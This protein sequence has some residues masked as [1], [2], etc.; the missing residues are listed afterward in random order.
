M[1]QARRHHREN[2]FACGR[3]QLE[4]DQGFTLVEMIV[5]IAILS[6]FFILIGT[7]FALLMRSEKTVMQSLLLERTI[8]RLSEQFRKDV[9]F[10]S[11]PNDPEPTTEELSEIVLAGVGNESVR[12]RVSKN[13]IERQLINQ[14]SVTARDSFVMPDCQAHFRRGNGPEASTFSIHI[15][16][17]GALLQRTPHAPV[18]RRE[19]EIQ[20]V[21]DPRMRMV[22]KESQAGPKSSGGVSP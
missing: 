16:R 2:P 13:G 18:P 6:G 15:R 5:V 12:Y 9:H 7:L 10:T 17:P 21:I 4:P 22:V 14:D 20:A 3:A 11:L 8:A 1:K 19:L